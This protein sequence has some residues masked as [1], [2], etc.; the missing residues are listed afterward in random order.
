MQCG[1]R[2]VTLTIKEVAARLRV[3]VHTVS[4]WCK[5]G[6]LLASDCSKNRGGRKRYR[7]TAAALSAFLV[8]RSAAPQI[9]HRRNRKMKTK[10]TEI[11]N[12]Y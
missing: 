11:I 8:A 1:G 4:S 6:E 12:F 3:D 5:S 7:I 9:T 2:A 10:D